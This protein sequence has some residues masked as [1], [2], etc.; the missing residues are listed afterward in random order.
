MVVG[1]E[2]RDGRLCNCVATNF[3]RSVLLLVSPECITVQVLRPRRRPGQDRLDRRAMAGLRTPQT[4]SASCDVV[5][6]TQ[7]DDITMPALCQDEDTDMTGWIATCMSW[8]RTRIDLRIQDH[9]HEDS[10]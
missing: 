5:A 6:R 10:G 7:V 8:N 9:L 3:V 4:Q 1:N 2:H